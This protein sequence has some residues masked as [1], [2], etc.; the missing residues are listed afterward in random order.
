MFLREMRPVGE[1]GPGS[2]SCCPKST[3]YAEIPTTPSRL[4]R[5]YPPMAVLLETN[6]DE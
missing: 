6:V 4:A 2:T 1:P 3:R 5:T